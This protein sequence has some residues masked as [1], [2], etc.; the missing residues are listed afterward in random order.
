MGGALSV[1]TGDD[2]NILSL[3][4]TAVFSRSFSMGNGG[5]ITPYASVGFDFSNIDVPPTNETDLSV[6]VRGGAEFWVSPEIRFM[7]ELQL[8]LSDS[9]R[10][11]FGFSAGVNLPF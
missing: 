10:D 3:G 2:Y 1:E 5:G 11:D 9:F 4:P 8:Q 6:P 7:A